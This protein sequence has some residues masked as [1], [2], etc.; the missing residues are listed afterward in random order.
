MYI[1]LFFILSFSLFLCFYKPFFFLAFFT[2]MTVVWWFCCV[3]FGMLCFLCLF[4]LPFSVNLVLYYHYVFLYNKSVQKYIVLYISILFFIHV[5]EGPIKTHDTC[6]S[7]IHT[8]TNNY[9]AEKASN[10]PFFLLLLRRRLQ[11]HR[12]SLTHSLQ[13]SQQQAL[14]SLFYYYITHS[15]IPFTITAPLYFFFSAY[16]YT[17]SLSLYFIINISIVVIIIVS[18]LCQ[19]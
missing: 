4:S 11:L 18:S 7:Q 10:L 8:H 16:F 19:N 1:L 12:L 9:Q 15:L 17:L 6:Q 13:L 14:F 5:E 2:S 3:V